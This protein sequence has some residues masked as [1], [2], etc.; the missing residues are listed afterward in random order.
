MRKLLFIAW[1]FPFF[2]VAQSD[3]PNI[4]LK[5]TGVTN[6]L[7]GISE[8]SIAIDPKNPS[9]MAAGSIMNAYYYSTDAGLT[10]KSYS[11]SSKY[12]VWGDPVLMFDTTGR[13]Y[14][15]H[16]SNYSKATWIDRIVCQS[17]PNVNAKFNT[18]TFPK[19]NGTK[20]QDKHWVVLDPKTNDIFM[21]WTQF[22]AYD[23][24]EP[25][26]SSRIMFS[27][28]TDQGKTWSD[29]MRISKYAGDCQDGDYTVEGAVPAVGPNGEIYVTWT[30]P[31]GLVFQRSL[32]RGKTWLDEEQLLHVHH[33]GWEM[34][35]P[36]MY[37]ANGLPILQC[38]LS[39]GANRGN[40]YLNWCDQKNG[41]NN[42]DS[43]L[44]VSEDGG[45]TWSEPRKVNQDTTVSHQFF[46][47][48]VVDQTS[49]YLYF[50]YYDR[51]NHND[52]QTDVYLTV[53]R[54]GGKTFTD[55][56]I[57]QK[58][59]LPDQEIFFG[60]YLNIAAVNGTIRPIWPRMD[61]GKTSLWIAL[62]QEEAL[63]K[64]SAK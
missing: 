44:S 12:G 55:H 14:Y 62:I 24:R 21:T 36:G 18:G 57:S 9:I 15:F 8:P 3:F 26:D 49:G 19:P 5:N 35:I 59:F 30:G 28:S 41:Y 10:W 1:I 7:N 34:T 11:L 13:V 60:D 43:W 50:V 16:L 47:W 46:T 61:D 39:N 6:V 32:D 37:R 4:Q 23:S 25:L 33:G 54:D 40:L 20:A 27:K 64:S 48:M 42:T 56:H 29:P 38:D 2:L 53:S 17:A 45:K 52:N 63:I 58:S 22:D 51:R 31:K